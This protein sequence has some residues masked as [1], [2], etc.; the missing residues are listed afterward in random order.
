MNKL[1]V[2]ATIAAAAVA[3]MIIIGGGVASAG[4]VIVPNAPGEIAIGDPTGT[5]TWTCAV[6]GPWKTDSVSVDPVTPAKLVGGFEPGAQVT[7]ACLGDT[8]PWIAFIN[9]PA[10]P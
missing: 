6:W 10:G 3:P 5:E 8:I 2:R 9:G 1:V 4:P 7:G